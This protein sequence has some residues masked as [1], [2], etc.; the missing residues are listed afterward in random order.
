VIYGLVLI[1]IV[2]LAPR[3]IAGLLTTLSRLPFRAMAR[4]ERG[5][6]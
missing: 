2:G 3:G 6:A 5:N 1:A 4:P